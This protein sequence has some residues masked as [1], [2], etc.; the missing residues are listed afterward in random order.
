MTESFGQQSIVECHV[1]FTSCRRVVSGTSFEVW[2]G[3]LVRLHGGPV[4][5]RGGSQTLSS[6]LVPLCRCASAGASYLLTRLACFHSLFVELWRRIVET[7]RLSSRS[8]VGSHMETSCG[9]LVGSNAFFKVSSPVRCPRCVCCC[10]LRCF[11][12][13]STSSEVLI[14]QRLPG[15]L[16]AR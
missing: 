2:S 3:C 1:P 5:K 7:G 9:S 16:G 8:R 14:P 13:L 12:S 15:T 4:C 11:Q 10:I 6:S